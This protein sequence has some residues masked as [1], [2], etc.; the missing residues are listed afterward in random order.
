MLKEIRPN[1]DAVYTVPVTKQDL[2]NL[3]D[4]LLKNYATKKIKITVSKS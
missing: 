4:D 2:Q 3:V 1:K